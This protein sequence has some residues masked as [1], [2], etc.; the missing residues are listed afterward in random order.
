MWR[1]RYVK[2]PIMNLQA[3]PLIN[4]DELVKNFTH[5]HPSKALWAILQADPI[6]LL[7]FLFHFIMPEHMEKIFCCF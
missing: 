7:G 4:K 1:F 2:K 3:F 5:L 6:Y